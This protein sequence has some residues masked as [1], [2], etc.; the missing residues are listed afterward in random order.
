MKRRLPEL[1]EFARQSGCL[2]PGCWGFI[3]GTL[4]PISRPV[5]GQEAVYSGHK[6]EHG[7]KYQ[8]VIGTDGL[9]YD[10]NGPFD[11]RRHDNF[12]LRESKLLERLD[13]IDPHS[14][15]FLYGDGAYYISSHIIG[16]HL[17]AVLDTGTA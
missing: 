15:Y 10:F 5:D 14:D 3:D 12:L 7:L 13:V 4:R 16:P 9:F 11:G 2:I 1:S 17:G 6:R 8:S